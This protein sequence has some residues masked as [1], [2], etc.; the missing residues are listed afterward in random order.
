MLYQKLLVGSEPY[1]ISYGPAARYVP[2]CHPEIELSYCAEG[3]YTVITNGIHRPLYA[4]D[5]SIISP[6]VP[7]DFTG[8]SADAK[9]LTIEIGP[10]FL[11]EYFDLFIQLNFSDGILHLKEG[12]QHPQYAELITLLDDTIRQWEHKEP[13][14]PLFIKGNL[15][16]I[17]ALILARLMEDGKKND[18]LKNIACVQ[19][20]ISIIHESY[21]QTLTLEEVADRCG[22]SKSN[23]CRIFKDTVG[24][25]FHATLNQHR[26][27]VAL[28]HLKESRLSIQDI[29][30]Q[31]GF[32]D[33]KQFC[34]I[35]K[36]L[37]H[38]SPGQY[39][40]N[41]LLQ[42]EPAE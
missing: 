5:L 20:A 3:S 41:V 37:M 26:I 28:L 39:R 19:Q 18:S 35:F 29:A 34:S 1:F 33:A 27:D 40:K 32:T 36:R 6:M 42:K 13:G 7:H 9:R 15:Y 31:V 8:C 11:G 38:V 24:D 21:H 4:G 2:H 10:C 23:F 16:R 25:T 12:T 14:Y 17:S 22:Y 30:Q